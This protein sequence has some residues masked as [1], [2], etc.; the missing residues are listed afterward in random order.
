[1]RPQI[2]LGNSK[3]SQA[4]LERIDEQAQKLIKALAANRAKVHA[5]KIQN[6]TAVD[7]LRLNWRIPGG[8]SALA[9]DGDFLWLGAANSLLLLHMGSGS[10]V[11]SFVMPVRDTISS[12]AVSSN[13][14]WVGT[15]YGDHKLLQIPKEPF[16]S[17]PRDQWASLA[18]SAQDRSRMVA[19]MSI[20]DR[21][22]YAFYAGAD[23]EV[24]NLLEN[25]DPQT[26]ALEQMFVLMFSYDTLGVDNP[27]L[28]RE[29]ADHISSRFPDSPWSKAAAAAVAENGH[30]HEI[31]RHDAL[32]L[33]KYDRNRD[34]VLDANERRAMEN[35]PDYQRGKQSWD[36]LQLDEQLKKIME[37]FDANGDGKLDR[38]E[39]EQL[40][41]QVTIFAQ[42]AP[43]IL[44]GHKVLVA[45]L[46][47]KHFPSVPTILQTYDTDRDGKL[48][49][50]ELNALAEAVRK[51]P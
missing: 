47:S 21:A 18:I 30:N 42:A 19:G 41:T 43:E 4:E 16:L 49:L 20:R 9:G 44:A 45:P 37:R 11:A 27:D 5:A 8:V 25:I 1:L 50:R 46:L 48:D 22:M 29:W 14:V 34:G 15:A 40:E 32:L 38:H 23:A 3:I 33:A 17:V 12:L 24:V 28:M 51:N 36:A 35:D 7:P 31:K 39:L 13:S 6:K 2:Y 10:L 26:A